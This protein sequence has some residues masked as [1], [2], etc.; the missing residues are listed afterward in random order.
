[1]VGTPAY[2]PPEQALGRTPDARSDLYALGATLYELLT[3]RPPFLGDDAV[4]IIS[5]HI[6][7][8]PVAPSWHNEAISKP[9]ENLVLRLLEKDPTVSR[10]PL[11]HLARSPGAPRLA[12]SQPQHPENPVALYKITS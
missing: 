7:T 5:Q 12:L 10:G 8:P 9:L 1:M 4:S 3:G 6:N 2:L 11:A